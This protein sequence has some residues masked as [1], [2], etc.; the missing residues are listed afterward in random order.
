MAYR[1][2]YTPGEL[3]QMTLASRTGRLFKIESVWSGFPGGVQRV[4]IL[5][6]S[7]GN[8]NNVKIDEFKKNVEEKDENGITA[9]TRI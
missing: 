4:E 1:F 9:L 5:D 6:V 7:T 2:S 3:K 8:I